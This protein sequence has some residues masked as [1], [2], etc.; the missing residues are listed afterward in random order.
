MDIWGLLALKESSDKPDKRGYCNKFLYNGSAHVQKWTIMRSC[1]L[2][3]DTRLL[4]SVIFYETQSSLVKN[5]NKFTVVNQ[6]DIEKKIV[7]KADWLVG[8][9]TMET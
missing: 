6:L 7:P 3:K 8:A 9:Y 2:L 4:G 1:T 5:K